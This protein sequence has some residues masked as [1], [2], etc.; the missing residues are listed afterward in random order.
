[1]SLLSTVTKTTMTEVKLIQIVNNDEESASRVL[2]NDVFQCNVCLTLYLQLCGQISRQNTFVSRGTSE[3]V[4]C[5]KR[6]ILS[7]GYLLKASST[8]SN[9]SIL[10]FVVF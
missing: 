9:K 7:E 4:L 3:L 8:C 6:C 2:I 5:D 1:M 10:Y